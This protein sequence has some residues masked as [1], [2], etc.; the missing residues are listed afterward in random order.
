MNAVLRY[1]TIISILAIIVGGVTYLQGER[2]RQISPAFWDMPQH[3]ENYQREQNRWRHLDEFMKSQ[4][5]RRAEIRKIVQ[6]ICK[7]E[8]GRGEAARRVKALETEGH[9]PPLRWPAVPEEKWPE[10]LYVCLLEHVV[11]ELGDDAEKTALFQ[12]LE[13][14]MKEQ[15]PSARIELPSSHE[16]KA[17]QAGNGVVVP[18]PIKS[19]D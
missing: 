18:S 6:A 10:Q 17:R 7:E 15:F 12:R 3:L 13:K 8:I 1:G 11:F 2:L 9:L 19:H 14:E 4:D 16:P 5:L